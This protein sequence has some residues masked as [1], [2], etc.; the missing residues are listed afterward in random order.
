[1]IQA[2]KY[3][4]KAAGIRFIGK[5]QGFLAFEIAF[6][7]QD[8]EGK[9]QILPWQ[10]FLKNKAG[11]TDAMEGTIKR[12]IEVLDYDGSQ[13]VLVVPEGDP[14]E[15][16]LKNQDCI[17]RT[18]DVSIEIEIETSTDAATGKVYNNPRIKWVNN[19]GGGKFAGLDKETIDND[20]GAI[21]F[22]AMFLGLSGNA[23]APRAQSSRTPQA[24]HAPVF[25]SEPEFTEEDLPF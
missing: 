14:K 16:Y 11:G 17:N 23:P 21:G 1:M 9:G 6:K 13:D 2:G 7:F 12:M 22:K 5:K 4:A 10:G 25:K 8:N 24:A 19:L 18:K 3:T 20:L 15:G